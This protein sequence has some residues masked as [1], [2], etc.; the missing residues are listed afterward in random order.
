MNKF[1]IY[2]SPVSL[3]QVVCVLNPDDSVTLTAH[4]K[5]S[6]LKYWLAQNEAQ[7]VTL[8]GP[9]SYIEGLKQQIDNNGYSIILQET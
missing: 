9:K 2:C 6:E 4:V 8:W 5:A 3:T 1:V 7:E